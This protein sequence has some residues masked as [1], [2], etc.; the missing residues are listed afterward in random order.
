MITSQKINKQTSKQTK[1]KEAKQNKTNKRQKWTI[2]EANV[3]SSN[4][5]QLN[6][7]GEICGCV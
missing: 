1:K 7:F 6:K 3:H 2:Q 4:L 5:M